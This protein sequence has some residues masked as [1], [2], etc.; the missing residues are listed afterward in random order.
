M[1]KIVPIERIIEESESPS[2]L[3]VDPDDVIEVNP[4]D[5]DEDLEEED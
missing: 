4:D 1:R 3:F 5:L 2:C